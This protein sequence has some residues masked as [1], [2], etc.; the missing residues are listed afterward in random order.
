M[1]T[2]Q[3]GM[4]AS[5]APEPGKKGQPQQDA[6]TLRP[7][8]DIF[9]IVLDQTSA[10]KG[11][12]T[13]A[14]ELLNP[15]ASHARHTVEQLR[16]FLD[17]EQV[18]IDVAQVLTQLMPVER[19]LAQQG[20]HPQVIHI[21]PC[22][23]TAE[24]ADGVVITLIN[25]S[26][27]QQTTE[28]LS[29]SEE[30]YRILVESAREYAIFM[31]DTNGQIRTWNSGAERIIGY[32][33]QE[34][35]GLNGSVIFTPEDRAAGVPAGEMVT[36]SQQGRAVDERWHLRKDGSRFWA[37]GMMEAVYQRDGQLRGFVKVLRDN[38]QQKQHEEA[39]EQLNESL[40]AQVLKRTE[41]VR[42]LVGQLTLSE[43]AERHRI[44]EV[45]HDDLQQRLYGLQYQLT[46]LRDTLTDEAQAGA[47]EIMAAIEVELHHSIQITRRLSIDLSPSVL[48][49]E[50]LGE[51]IGWLAN[52]MKGQHG[53]IVEVQSAADLPIPTATLRILL[54]Q[55]I[56]ELLFN[57]VKHAGVK[58]A[59]VTLSHDNHQ[60]HIEVADR[61]RGFDAATV[62]NQFGRAHG[63]WQ[64][65]RRLELIGGY[66][67]IE[68][69][70][71]RGTRAIV[72]CPLNA[73]S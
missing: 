60:L 32:R 47:S 71:G 4:V 41:Q 56:R 18:K 49:G 39:I 21:A 15:L 46:F 44:A 25:L 11:Y 10:V 73:A 58:T 17:D 28:A 43:Q 22:W 23:T 14:T 36:A 34:A 67:Q 55:T 48:E 57:I 7:A 1:S 5:G 68:S 69:Q 20:A 2:N 61:G 37:S 3:T 30:R 72:T 6:T 45:L 52:Q 50:G 13:R 54:F 12:T 64:K 9:S 59:A 35:I 16:T 33:E 40:E 51:A 62:L 70:P 27:Y 63:L 42:E 66:L 8:I 24:T 29:E 31:L 38:T 26:A 19:E 65:Q 53:L